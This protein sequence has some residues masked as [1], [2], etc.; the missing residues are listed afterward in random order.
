MSLLRPLA[1]LVLKMRE[2]SGKEDPRRR[3]ERL[4][5]ASAARPE[6]VLVLGARGERRRDQR[7]AAADRS[8]ERR[9][10]RPQLSADHR[11][12]DVGG[13]RRA[14]PARARLHQYVPL[15]AP[16]YAARFLDHWRPD[17]AIFTESEIWPSL[18]LETAARAIPLALV[19]GRLSHR[20]R[21][22]WQRNKCTAHAAVRPLRLVLAQ[23][24]RLAH[25]FSALGARNVLSVG[26]LKIDAPPPPVDL[27]ELER[28]QAGARRAP[29]A[30]SPPARTR[31]RRRSSR[32][33]IGSWRATSRASAPSS[34]RVIP[35]AARRLPR[36]CKTSASRWRSARSARC[37]TAHRH[38]HR[39]HHRRARD[40]LCA[41]PRR[42]HR[43]LARRSRR[44]E[45]HRGRA[46]RRRRPDRAAL[47][48]LPRRLPHAAAPPRRHRGE[49][50]RDTRR[51][52]RPAPRQTRPSCRACAR[53]RRRRSRPCRARSTRRSRRCCATSP[54]RD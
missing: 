36:C 18:I 8:A 41:L 6:G 23:N 31:A 53:A 29:G 5:Q 47:A 14:A 44:A 3:A 21:R 16:E 9:A 12:G 45:P 4:G 52:G 51:R 49:L 54:T 48:E 17:L 13:P 50:R 30:S 43:R 10:A 33:R 32:K 22:R 46:P 35:S 20:S 19:N 39:R 28:L 7:R 11:H 37:R 42:L 25:G 24:E 26:N 40:A 15:D 34:P 27:A 1:P 38:L 2:R